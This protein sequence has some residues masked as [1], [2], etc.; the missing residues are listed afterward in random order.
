MFSRFARIAARRTMHTA[1]NASSA[2]SSSSKSFVAAS[3]A[4]ATVAGAFGLSQLFSSNMEQQT[5][6]LAPTN[7]TDG[8]TIYEVNCHVDTDVAEDF[9]VWL[10]PHYEEILKLDGFQSA[11]MFEVEREPDNTPNVLFV[12]G[13]PGAGKGTQCGNIV[14][15]YDYEHIS[16][17][18]C[19]REER[20]NPDS[21]NG[22]LINDYIKRGAIV[23]VEITIAL[24]LKKMQNSPK[25]KFLIDGFPRNANNLQG[26]YDVVGDKANVEGVL[27]FDCSEE[28]LTSRLLGR[29]AAAG[30]NRRKDDNIESI[31][32]RFRT[33]QTA[34]RP[35][36]QTYENMGKCITVD[37]NTGTIEEVFDSV[38]PIIEA[39]DA[40]LTKKP[41][42][43]ITSVYRVAE[44]EQLED[45]FNNHAKRLRGDGLKAFAGKF[46]ADRRV[47]KSIAKV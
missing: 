22:A 10:K 18:D 2:S 12:L 42:T 40:K 15:N 31:K 30:K 6:Q 4:V 36:I 13:G 16:A 43:T 37:A 25:T 14:A 11:E 20:N 28:T 44:R 35:I 45:Y 39:M 34:T 38:K 5:V 8:A 41:Q 1:A 7:G 33:Y 46:S 19:L 26:W 3:T 27:F 23:P 47:M 9:K 24:L 17:G 32:K 29:A 21:E